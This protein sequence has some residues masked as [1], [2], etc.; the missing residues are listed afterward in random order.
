MFTDEGDYDVLF[1]ADEPG[2]FGE[3]LVYNTW[4]PRLVVGTQGLVATPWHRTHEQWGATQMQ[5]RFRRT[6]GRWMTPVD[7][8][9]WIAARSVGEAVTRVQTTDFE[10]VRDY[11][12]GPEFSLA[13]YKGIKV[14]YR[15]WNGQLRQRLLL[16]SP[17]A[18]ISVSPQ[19]G[20]LHPVSETDTLGVDKPETK[21][22]LAKTRK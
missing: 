2:E 1:V 18:L 16:S 19:E 21:C 4:D 22:K 11:I 15:S 5:N 20:Y 12:I 14:N 17:R 10:K 9:A 7:Y 6:S 3:Y 13:A 8:A